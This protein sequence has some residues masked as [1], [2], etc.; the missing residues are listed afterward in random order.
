MEFKEWANDHRESLGPS[1]A[2]I[3]REEITRQ[4]NAVLKAIQSIPNL[5]LLA[6]DELKQRLGELKKEIA[7]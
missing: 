7:G 1:T 2:S 3:S 6:D 4:A 5:A